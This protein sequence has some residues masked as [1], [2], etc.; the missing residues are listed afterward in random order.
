MSIAR[1]NLKEAGYGEPTNPWANLWADGQKSHRRL[2][3]RVN[4]QAKIKPDSYTE[5]CAVDAADRW[6]ERSVWYPGRSVRDA[7]KGATI[8]ER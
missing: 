7:L 1:W 6:R 2:Y 3:M 8:I 5:S 4:L